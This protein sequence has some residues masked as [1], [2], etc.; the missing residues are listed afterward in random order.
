VN[1]VDEKLFYDYYYAIKASE[2]VKFIIVKKAF[3]VAVEY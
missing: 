2:A 1:E 3:S